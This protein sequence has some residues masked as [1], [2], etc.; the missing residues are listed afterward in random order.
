MA[1][2]WLQRLSG[3]TPSVRVQ[4]HADQ[5][6]VVLRAFWAA[7]LGVEPGEI[8]FHPKTNSSQLRTRTWRCADGVVAVAIHDTL[9]RIRLQA[10]MD[11]VFASWV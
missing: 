5:D 11:R 1:A 7:T 10:W 3:R 4:Y 9:L 8:R 2:N 6:T